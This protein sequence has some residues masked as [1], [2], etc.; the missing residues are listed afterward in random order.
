MAKKPTATGLHTPVTNITQTESAA[1]A[2]RISKGTAGAQPAQQLTAD[3][4]TELIPRM[5]AAFENAA[6]PFVPDL[7]GLED[8]GVA[9]YGPPSNLEAVI[10]TDERVRVNETEKYPWCAIASLLITAADNSM[11]I[12]TG[13]FISPTTLITAG[14]CVYIQHNPVPARNG[15]VKKIQVLP[16]RNADAAPFG[17]ISATTF[18]TV[19]GWADQGLEN[20]DYAAIMLPAPFSQDLGSFSF[21]VFVDSDLTNK[22]VNV[23]GYPSDKPKGTIWYDNRVIGSMNENKIYYAADTAGGQ[24]GCPVYIVDEGQ[25]IAIAIHAYGGNTANSGTRISPEVF[26][27]LESWKEG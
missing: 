9:T 26:T 24:S 10:G 1:T 14:H 22:M 17:G 21:G 5:E 3:G 7:T 2:S 27:N 8:I 25:R 16:G 18:W 4:L 13:W 11:W 19:K 6:I 12:G 20:Y 15:W 23:P